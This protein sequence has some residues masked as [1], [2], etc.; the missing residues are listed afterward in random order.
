MALQ[1]PAPRGTRPA[2]RRD[3]IDG[4]GSGPARPAAAATRSRAHAAGEKGSIERRAK[5]KTAAKQTLDLALAV[6]EPLGAA[7]WVARARDELSRIGLRRVVVTE[8]LTP[9]Q[10]RVA[11]LAAEGA[12]SEIA[13]ALYMSVRTVE[14]APHQDLRRAQIR[15][16]A[17]LATALAARARPTPPTRSVTTP[18]PAD[19]A[20]T[21]AHQSLHPSPA[22][23]RLASRVMHPDH[24]HRPYLREHEHESRAAQGP[25]SA[26]RQSRHSPRRC[27][28]VRRLER[29]GH[30]IVA[31]AMVCCE[32]AGR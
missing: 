6:L 20:P 5:H 32:A 4:R 1:G 12:T 31:E 10:E 8:G 14:S 23:P 28:A 17:Q 29:C 19:P 25:P 3:R 11:E 16:R 9:A 13:R 7:I 30:P 22:R 2:R 24:P 15:S 26:P 18:H 21:T 27:Q